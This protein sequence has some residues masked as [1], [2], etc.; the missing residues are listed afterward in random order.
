MP[1]EASIKD[2]FARSHIGSCDRI[3]KRW[4][5]DTLESDLFS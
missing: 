5:A 2:L 4:A 1:K 3:V